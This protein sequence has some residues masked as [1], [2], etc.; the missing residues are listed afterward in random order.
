[1]RAL[2]WL[3]DSYQLTVSSHGREG[4]KEIE[5]GRGKEGGREGKG[6][7]ESLSLVSLLIR[8]LIPS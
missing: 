5:R 8:T 7:R 2:F 1:M 3:L 4:G 6:E